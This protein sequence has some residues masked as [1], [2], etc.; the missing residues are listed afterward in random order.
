LLHLWA[1]DF[2]LG[3]E[4]TAIE[5]PFEEETT[6]LISSEINFLS[7]VSE[8]VDQGSETTG[9]E[10]VAYANGLEGFDSISGDICH[11]FLKG[12]WMVAKLCASISRR[13]SI[14]VTLDDFLFRQSCTSMATGDFQGY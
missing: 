10:D 3:V 6:S 11:R 9:V 13:L 8:V 2:E 4:T 12:E 7:P 5:V 14:K 1:R